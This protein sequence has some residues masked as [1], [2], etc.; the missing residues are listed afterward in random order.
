MLLVEFLRVRHG[1]W[2]GL[3]LR[4]F[5]RDFHSKA[6][7]PKYRPTPMSPGSTSACTGR[8]G[9]V[10]DAR[11]RLRVVGCKLRDA[12]L[13]APRVLHPLADVVAVPLALHLHLATA[14][15]QRVNELATVRHDRVWLHAVALELVD[16]AVDAMMAL[17]RLGNPRTDVLRSAAVLV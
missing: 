9:V 11:V 13:D 3:E 4:W 16:P 17:S 15:A 2:E 6:P 1:R 14:L 7:N 8:T 5:R 12:L 10:F